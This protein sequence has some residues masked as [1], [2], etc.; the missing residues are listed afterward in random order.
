M[1]NL[2]VKIPALQRSMDTCSLCTLLVCRLEF[3]KAAS[4]D[5]KK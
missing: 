4:N 1:D 2:R 3:P 5:G